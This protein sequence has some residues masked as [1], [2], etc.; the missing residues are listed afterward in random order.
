MSKI[1]VIMAVYNTKP[2]L[3]EAIESVLNQTFW[4]FEFIIVDDYSTDG[5]YEYLQKIQ[6]TDDR[7]KL[8]RNEKNMWISFTRNKLI[9][10]T[11]TN[12]IATQDSDD[13][14]E[15]DRLELSYN[16]LEN[17]PDYGVVSWN[18][19][20]INEDSKV[21]WYRKYHNNIKSIILK[22]SPI[23]QWSSLFK[24]DILIKLWWYDK[25]LDFWEDY[26]LWI[27]MFV[28]WYKIWNLDKYLYSVRIRKWQSKS[29][30]LKQT[31]KNT[32]NIQKKAIKLW[33]K[34]S[35]SDLIYIFLE[36]FLLILPSNIILF[37]FKKLEYKNAK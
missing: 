3:K 11:N 18:N 19:I 8:Y 2:Y 25:S 23:S 24:K 34:P 29:S 13:I 10:L 37:L 32:I 7:I 16:F 22:K 4:E 1:S 27:R 31:I 15:L 36:H 5:S 33:L 26:D 28:S 17:N 14:S 6:K 20:I 9:S 30:K 35:F 21:I 12:Y